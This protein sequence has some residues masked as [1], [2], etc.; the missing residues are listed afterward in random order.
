MPAQFESVLGEAQVKKSEALALLTK[1]DVTAEELEVAD[2]LMVEAENLVKKSERLQ[3]LQARADAIKGLSANDRLHHDQVDSGGKATEFKSFG[4]FLLAVKSRHIRPD[5]R[6]RYFA[7]EVEEAEHKDLS[8]GLGASGGI[9]VPS[10]Y[11]ATLRQ[12]TAEM[13][14]VRPRANVIPMSRRSIEIPALRQDTTTANVPHWF[15]GMLAFWESEAAAITETEPQFRNIT[16]TAHEITAVT[17]V[18]NNL[19][20]DSAVSLSALLT[21]P[22]GFPGVVAWKED[23]AFLRG[24]GVGEPLGV[25]N[26]PAVVDVDRTTANTVTFDDLALMMTALLPSSNAVW[27][28]NLALKS[29]LLRMHGPTDTNYGGVYMWGSA[30]DGVPATL[31]GLPIIFTE[32]LP[33]VGS[34]GDLILCDFSHYYVGDR[35]A[36]TID[37]TDQPRWL[38]NQTSWKVTARVDGQPWI[39][40]PF[41]LAD[42][43]TTVSPFVVLDVPAGG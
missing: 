27:V 32:K 25:L 17:H 20:A 33:A 42:G 16:L 1:A 3:S 36:T 34:R 7:S 21:G 19:L 22:R 18:S 26:S 37:S 24:S 41:T 38:N 13:A 30:K 8:E 14:I 40:A 12:V 11:D 10:Q 4:E 5:S 15:G 9:L 39:N 6:L 35:K 23:W 28:A 29:H 31:M 43:T 2:R